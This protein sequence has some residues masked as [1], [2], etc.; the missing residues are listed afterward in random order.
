MASL[1]KL[2]DQSFQQEAALVREAQTETDP[3]R[4]QQIQSQLRQLAEGR[5]VTASNTQ[6]A[7]A[8]RGQINGTVG[9]TPVANGAHD[10]D[11]RV[12]AQQSAAAEATSRVNPI[13]DPFE[14]KRVDPFTETALVNNATIPTGA[15]TRAKGLR[16][17]SRDMGVDMSN[18]GHIGVAKRVVQEAL[19]SGEPVDPAE[20]QRKIQSGVKEFTIKSLQEEKKVVGLKSDI[21][22]ARKKI[23]ENAKGK[24][25][26]KKSITDLEKSAIDS[27]KLRGK[28]RV[29]GDRLEPKFFNRFS[30]GRLAVLK[31]AQRL[32]KTLTV[33][34]R[35]DVRDFTSFEKNVKQI[36]N[37]YR[38]AITGAQASEKEIKILEDSFLSMSFSPDE[39]KS[40]L[41]GLSAMNEINII[42]S[43]NLIEQ[44][45]ES[46]SL[47]EL[48]RVDERVAKAKDKWE[49]AL[50]LAN[51]KEDVAEG[52]SA[53]SEED[54]NAIIEELKRR[55]LR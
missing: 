18:P 36:F 20:L 44:G 1:G 53:M 50:E 22:E 32:G 21:I 3:N 37:A 8:L 12:A 23:K 25:L 45:L 9:V 46:D 6:R 55:G 33:G 15:A 4:L 35:Q 41:E 34:Q 13:Q 24:G 54:R 7:N 2:M 47:E 38:K 17:A 29:L 26:S 43:Q 19:K 10:F 11:P 31:E 30:Q 40:A 39:F 28:L 48:A 14:G 42:M 27:I 49:A 51:A 16:Q 52:R 5:T